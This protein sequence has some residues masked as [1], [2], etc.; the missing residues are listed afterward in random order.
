MRVSELNIEELKDLK[1]QLKLPTKKELVYFEQMSHLKFK[2]HR[3]VD[4]EIV[5]EFPNAP[6]SMILKILLE[7]DNTVNI[8]SDYLSEMQKSN[9]IEIVSK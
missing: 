1:K 7:N 8:L 3:V 4:F 5:K 2:P 9:F 6:N